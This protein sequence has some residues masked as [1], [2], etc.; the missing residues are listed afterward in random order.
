MVQCYKRAGELCH[1]EQRGRQFHQHE[2]PGDTGGHRAFCG[3][4]HH[5]QRG[6]IPA[7]LV[8][9]HQLVG[10]AAALQSDQSDSGARLRRA[11]PR[12][13][14]LQPDH[15]RL[16]QWP[17]QPPGGQP[18]PERDHVPAVH[19]Q[20]ELRR[21]LQSFHEYHVQPLQ[22]PAER[23][24]FQFHAQPALKPAELHG[25]GEGHRS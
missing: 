19:K 2:H 14:Q 1:H 15:H 21:N 24:R 11:G 20:R 17:H 8:Q 4:P 12:G 25:A 18:G 5:L 22:L 16:F 9:H 6:G 23:G 3:A 7:L 13:E 10:A